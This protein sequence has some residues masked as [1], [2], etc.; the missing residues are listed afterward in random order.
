[1]NIEMMA[2]IGVF[3]IAIFLYAIYNERKIH[4]DKIKFKKDIK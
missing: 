3:V 2:F 1:M 4:K